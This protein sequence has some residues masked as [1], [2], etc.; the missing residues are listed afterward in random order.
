MSCYSDGLIRRTKNERKNIDYVIEQ[1]KVVR[2]QSGR[3]RITNE[4]N[5][6]PNVPPFNVQH[7]CTES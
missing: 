4:G 6:K 5:S 1:Y 2:C 3:L 7:D